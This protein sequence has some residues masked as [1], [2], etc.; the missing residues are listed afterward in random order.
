MTLC[1]KTIITHCSRP[2]IYL[3]MSIFDFSVI[4]ILLCFVNING[5]TS[6][7][8]VLKLLYSLDILEPRNSSAGG[9]QRFAILLKDIDWTLTAK[10]KRHFAISLEED[11]DQTLTIANKR[12]SAI[13]LEDIDWTSAILAWNSSA[14]KE[15]R[16]NS[17]ASAELKTFVYLSRIALSQNLGSGNNRYLNV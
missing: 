16:L 14:G 6:R 13:S 5:R 1:F 15:Q 7:L 8:G 12:R 4:N 9:K 2:L 10:N 17:S 11:I 3:F